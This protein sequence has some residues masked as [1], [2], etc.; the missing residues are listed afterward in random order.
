MKISV[1]SITPSKIICV[2]L[3]YRNHARELKM[4]IPKEPLI[5][6]KPPSSVIYNR[7]SIY[8]PDRVRRLDFEAEL[9][10]VIKKKTK[11]IKIKDVRKHILGFTCL[12]DI[13]ARDLQIKDVQ[14]TRSKSFD[15]FCPIG[16]VIE[17]DLE[18]SNLKIESRLNGILK[19]SSTTADFIFPVT[20]LVVFIS[21]IM[22]L[23]PGDIISTGTPQGV[24]QLKPRDTIEI[25]IEGIG[26]LKNKVVSAKQVFNSK[27][28]GRAL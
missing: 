23:F 4:P 14:W 16:P 21:R 19:Q 15:T 8:Y 18:V 6:L 10:V 25:I 26:V 7:N 9:G 24:D 28:G 1:R 27:R 12:N 5:F 2:G 17:T 11:N 22:T 20:E 13:T 3:N